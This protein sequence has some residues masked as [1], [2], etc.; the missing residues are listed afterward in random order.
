MQAVLGWRWTLIEWSLATQS[1]CGSMWK[2][3]IY[4]AREIENKF[5]A[6][7]KDRQKQKAVWA[8]RSEALKTWYY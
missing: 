8:Q 1:I 5:H 7:D 6:A 4:Q 2:I 3:V